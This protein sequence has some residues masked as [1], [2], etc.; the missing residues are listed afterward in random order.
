MVE[1]RFNIVN[2]AAEGK[3]RMDKEFY[4]QQEFQF[5]CNS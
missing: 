4:K 5:S 2:S 1:L 3:Y